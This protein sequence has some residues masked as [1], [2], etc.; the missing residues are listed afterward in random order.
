MR[1]QGKVDEIAPAEAAEFSR[2]S[3]GQGISQAAY[4]TSYAVSFGVV[5]PAVLLAAAGTVILPAPAI[6]GLKHG[7][8]G[9]KADADRFLER[10]NAQADQPSAIGPS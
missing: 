5:F 1:D 7:A 9:A 6:D 3:I 8:A 2:T 4:S 10:V